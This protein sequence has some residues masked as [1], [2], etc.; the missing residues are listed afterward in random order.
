MSVNELMEALRAQL[1][2]ASGRQAVIAAGA[3]CESYVRLLIKDPF[4]DPRIDIFVCSATVSGLQVTTFGR[5]VVCGPSWA[6][7]FRFTAKAAYG[8]I[9]N[10]ARSS[11]YK[12]STVHYWARGR[13]YPSLSEARQLS[14]DLGSTFVAFRR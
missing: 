14:L 13:H 9:N 12:R 11:G 1:S 8:S 4:L 5:A 2:S 10:F 7:A 6:S 3:A